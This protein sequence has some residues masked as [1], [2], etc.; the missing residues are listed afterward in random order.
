[1][2]SDAPSFTEPKD[3]VPVRKF[4]LEWLGYYSF[5]LCLS[6]EERKMLTPKEIANLAK[7]M[8]YLLGRE[9]LGGR[10]LWVA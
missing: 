7:E 10:W 2:S 4:A 3:V 6:K 1:M 8:G 5:V 9:H